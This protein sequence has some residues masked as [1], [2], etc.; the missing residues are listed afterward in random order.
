MLRRKHRYRNLAAVSFFC[1]RRYKM[2]PVERIVEHMRKTFNTD[3]YCGP[4]L[5]A[6][7]SFPDTLFYLIL[8]VSTTVIFRICFAGPVTA[9]QTAPSM[10]ARITRSSHPGSVHAVPQR[11][12]T[13]L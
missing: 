12:V 6:T 10:T 1:L 2:E 13:R 8:I 7:Q 5:H 11:S 3:G 9:R 4:E